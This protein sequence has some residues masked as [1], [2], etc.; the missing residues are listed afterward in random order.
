MLFTHII[1]IYLR[2]KIEIWLYLQQAGI[3]LLNIFFHRC[4]YKI[5]CFSAWV[6]VQL[7]CPCANLLNCL[8]SVGTI[9]ATTKI[10]YN[11]LK[12]IFPKQFLTKTTIFLLFWCILCMATPD[13]SSSS[14]NINNPTYVSGLN[15]CFLWLWCQDFRWIRSFLIILLGKRNIYKKLNNCMP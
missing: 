2:K 14:E 6:G 13:M 10:D 15:F 7:Q 5:S 4:S 8:R 9:V 1:F 11:S 3:K 12:V